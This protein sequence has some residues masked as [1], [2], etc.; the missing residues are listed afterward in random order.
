MKKQQ[1]TTLQSHCLTDHLIISNVQISSPSAS[2]FI[3]QLIKRG[4]ID[5]TH[6]FHL[7]TSTLSP[8][9]SLMRGSSVQ[10]IQQATFSP[11][12]QGNSRPE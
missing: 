5:S 3:Q 6:L 4:F 1:K 11:L 2:C 12:E 9:F 7:V 10:G 8:G